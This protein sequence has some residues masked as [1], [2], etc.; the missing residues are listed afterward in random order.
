M[1]R[2][3]AQNFLNSKIYLNISDFNKDSFYISEN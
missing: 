3:K 2:P 1:S